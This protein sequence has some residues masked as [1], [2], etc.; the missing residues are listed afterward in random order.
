MPEMDEGGF[1]LDYWTPA[2][3]SLAET[4]RMISHIED[5]VK[6]VPEVESTSRRTG[7]ELGLA[8][9]TEANRGDILVKLKQKRS[10]DIDEVMEEIRQKVQAQEPAVVVEFVQVLQDMIG[11]LTSEPEPIQIKLFSQN[12]DELRSWAPKVADSIRKIDG[13]VD[14]LDGIENTI[15]SPAVTFEIDPAVASRAGFT[16]EEIATDASALVEGEPASAPVVSNDRVYTV[17]V[18]FPEANRRSLET[19]SNTLLTSAN[20]HTATLGSHRQKSG[21]RIC[22]VTW[23]LPDEP[24]EPILAAPWRRFKRRSRGFM[25]RL[26]SVWNTAEPTSSSRSPLPIFCLYFYSRLCWCSRFSYSN[27]EPSPLPSQFWLLRFCRLP[28]FL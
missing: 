17:R 26:A 24:K 19:I 6:E 8:A 2:G 28:G 22:C 12:P 20:G 14:V 5:I 11:D 1:T 23:R 3:A 7:L 4:N 13:V 16:P 18:R 10:R 21:G 27:S 25:F 9:V 15:S